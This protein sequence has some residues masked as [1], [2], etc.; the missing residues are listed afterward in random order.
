MRKLAN[1]FW[2]GTKELRALAKDLTMILFIIWSFGFS[3]YMQ[4]TGAGETVNNAAIGIV[5][6][7]QSQ[8]SRSIAGLFYPPYFQT[9]KTISAAD[10]D[11]AMDEGHYTFVV[12]IPPEFERHEE[13]KRHRN[14][15]ECGR[16][17]LATGFAR[18]RLHPEHGDE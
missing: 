17:G 12:V 3:I 16:H 1:I 9:V 13:G 5:D 4:S 15:G 7:D 14:P 2:L 11:R 8:L 18:C 6:E 10:I